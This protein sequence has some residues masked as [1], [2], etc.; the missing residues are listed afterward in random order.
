MQNLKKKENLDGTRRPQVPQP[1]FVK[2]RAFMKVV[3]RGDAFL[4]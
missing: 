2:A 1:L 4:I 3:K